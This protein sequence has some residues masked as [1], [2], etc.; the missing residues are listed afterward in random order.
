MISKKSSR[1]SSDVSRKK[2]SS[3]VS[4]ARSST[5]SKSQVK[6]MI[7]STLGNTLEDKYSDIVFNASNID[8]A[9]YAPFSLTD[10]A[11]GTTDTSRVGDTIL[12]KKLTAS[13]FFTYNATNTTTN[14]AASQNLMR[15]VIF[16]WK[17]FFADVAPTAAKVFT[18]TST[19]Y[20]AMGP[21]THDGIDQLVILHDELFALDGF[22]NPNRIRRFSIPLNR[23]IQFKAGS[24]TNQA[25]GI[26]CTFMSNASA[27]P[28]PVV[29]QGIFRLDFQDA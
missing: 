10:M 13:V 19:A 24:S 15:F 23:K 12:A 3:R 1:K 25:G 16:V 14:L 29:T 6:Q 28:F 7:H 18:Y 21:L 2:R 20:S 11:Q 8:Y 5:V 9:G 4:N 22:V 17:P 27:A 26:Y